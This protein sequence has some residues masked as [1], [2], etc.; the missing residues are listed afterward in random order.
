MIF[1]CLLFFVLLFAYYE[2]L[3]V[4]GV[5]VCRGLA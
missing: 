4:L 3:L 1:L 5:R 2:L